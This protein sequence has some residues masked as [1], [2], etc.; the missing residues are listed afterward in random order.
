MKV[1]LHRLRVRGSPVPKYQ[2][3]LKRPVEGILTVRETRD[4]ILN[5]STR[6]ARLQSPTAVPPLLDVQLIELT[7]ERMILS[8]IERHE[9]PVLQKIEDFAQT[10][11]CWFD[12]EDGATPST[13]A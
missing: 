10:W 1:H 8:G 5:R 4:D 11:L 7:A 3:A 2:F 12:G 9:D 6:I 13:R